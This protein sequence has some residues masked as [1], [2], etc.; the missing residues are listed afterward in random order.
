MQ[1]LSAMW[2][3]HPIWHRMTN[4]ELQTE[5]VC[6]ALCFRK[7]L[8]KYQE[9]VHSPYQTPKVTNT[10]IAKVSEGIPWQTSG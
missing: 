6:P 2:V 8:A 10:F 5:L 9:R 3:K 1:K 4:S 7:S